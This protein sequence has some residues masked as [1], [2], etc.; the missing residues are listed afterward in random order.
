M[1]G[2]QTIFNIGQWAL[3]AQQMGIAVTSHNVANV[4]T[5]GFSRQRLILEPAR[6][7]TFRPGQIGTGVRAAS[8]ERVYDQFLGVQLR[9]EVSDQG[10]LESRV[11]G[12]G[13]LEAL[14]SGLSDQD[15]ASDL[16]AFWAS[17][18]DLSTHPEGDAERVGVR[19]TGRRLVERIRGLAENLDDLAVQMDQSVSI[20]LRQA[21]DLAGQIADL[22]GEIERTENSG[23]NANDLRDM[24]DQALEELSGIVDVQTWEN[25]DGTVSV[26]GPGG[27][28]LVS[29][30]YRWSLATLETEPDR[31]SVVWE[32]GHGNQVDITSEIRSGSVGGYLQIR[33][34]A[35][36]RRLE[37]LDGLAREL[38]WGVNVGQATSVGAAP[39]TQASSAAPVPPGDALMSSDLPFASRIAPG[40]IHLWL[41][42][43]AEPPAALGRVE[44]SV[45]AGTTLQD[46]A[47]QINADPD[48]GGRILATVDSDGILSLQGQGGARF[49]VTADDSNVMA[50]IGL[51]GFFSGSSAHDLDISEAVRTDA[52]VI[53]SGRAED[54]DGTMAPGDNR[55][56]LDM[57]AL[58]DAKVLNGS[59][60]ESAY[61][62]S[63]AELGLE[64]SAAYRGGEY[65]DLVVAQLREQRSSVSGV[66]L[67]E[68]MMRLMEYQWAYEA[69]ARLIQTGQEML[70]TILDIKR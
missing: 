10:S 69:A 6:A 66:S 37:A 26:M 3:Q 16:Q 41:Y 52:G 56:V 14:Y 47:D 62:T 58:R 18:E 67:D 23:Q 51:G 45:D 63:V 25:E 24:R 61:A 19:E 65:Q 42:D 20:A 13:Q 12:Y 46:V 15:L 54:G 68:E 70:Q 2:I 8:I 30:I 40:E 21:S 50:A 43:G 22:N 7:E 44:V 29:G 53:G 57:V 5:P 34:E 32:D 17:W 1:A 11:R 36:P 35:I 33:D 38:I 31:S 39:Q 27:V 49:A 28:P 60:L 9:S 59:T 48:N 64:A 55:A 4:N